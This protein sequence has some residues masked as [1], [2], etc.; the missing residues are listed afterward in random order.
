MIPHTHSVAIHQ[1]K[2]L[3]EVFGFGVNQFCNHTEVYAL[4]LIGQG[5]G[6]PVQHHHQ[7]VYGII[8]CFGGNNLFLVVQQRIDLLQCVIANVLETY[9]PN[10]MLEPQ[11]ALPPSAFDSAKRPIGNSGAFFCSSELFL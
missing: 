8:D 4:G 9:E 6:Y 2:R 7:S 1:V 3:N 11:F 10:R 5:T